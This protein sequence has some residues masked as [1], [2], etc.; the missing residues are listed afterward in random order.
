M[1]DVTLPRGRFRDASSL[2]QALRDQ[3]V[4]QLVDRCTAR[5]TADACN[6]D[7]EVSFP[8]VP[9]VTGSASLDAIEA[10]LDDLSA[11]D[12]IVQSELEAT[13]ELSNLDEVDVRFDLGIVTLEDDTVTLEYWGDMAGA[14]YEVEFS[15]ED[16]RWQRA[17]SPPTGGPPQQ[18]PTPIT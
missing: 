1:S 18:D 14:G 15:R 8:F 11:L 3:R 5:I 10:L 7:F 12:D 4:T 6:I 13:A 16:G 17:P 9:D 2:V